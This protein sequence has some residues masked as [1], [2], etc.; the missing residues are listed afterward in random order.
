MKF[1]RTTNPPSQDLAEHDK[2]WRRP[3]SD[4]SDFFN[5]GFDEFTWATYCLKQQTMRNAINEQK[6]ESAKFEMMFGGGM[7]GMPAQQ[8]QQVPQGAQGMAQQGGMPDMNPDMMNAMAQQ[9]M[10]SGMDPSQMDFGTFMQ[11]FQSMQ[12][13]GGG[14]P[15]GPQ[16]YG[17]GQAYGNGMMD[18]GAG[19]G[20]GS[21]QGG[22]GGRNQG[23]NYGGRG[24]GRRW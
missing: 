12:G 21:A 4:Q 8:Q 3:G 18:G 11:Q 5:Y 15:S 7:P 23:G 20:G 2:P 17:G 19:G 24:R 13:G 9:M 22:A 6:A 16:G 10:A 1:N 14:V